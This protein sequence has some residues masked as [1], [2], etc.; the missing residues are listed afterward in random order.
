VAS[1]IANA[2]LAVLLVGS[3]EPLVSEVARE[4]RARGVSVETTSRTDA[5]DAAFVHAPDLAVVLGDAA[6]DAGDAVLAVLAA[7][8]ATAV[9]PVVVVR[10]PRSSGV[11]PRG[12]GN[13]SVSSV[14]SVDRWP[15]PSIRYQRNRSLRQRFFRTA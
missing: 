9:I 13:H 2:G 7:K 1:K 5:R 3:E 6:A 8:T 10:P 4:L 12:Y 11:A 14:T 15:S